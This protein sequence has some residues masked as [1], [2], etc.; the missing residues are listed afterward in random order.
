M[1][2]SHSMQPTELNYEIYDKELL[3]IFEAFQQWCN[4]LRGQ[5]TLYLMLSNHKNLEYYVTTM[6]LT[7]S[8]SP[9]VRIP[10]W[11]QLFDM[12]PCRKVGYQAIVLT[13]NEDVYPWGE[14]A[15][16]LANPPR[17]TQSNLPCSTGGPNWSQSFP[18]MPM[19]PPCHIPYSGSNPGWN[20]IPTASGTQAPSEVTWPSHDDHATTCHPGHLIGGPG[21]W[22]FQ[23]SFFPSISIL[24]HA[25]ASLIAPKLLYAYLLSFPTWRLIVC[26]P[27]SCLHPCLL[28]SPLQTVTIVTDTLWSLIQ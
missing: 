3:A 13:N 8:P 7:S 23:P 16:M 2:Y 22:R 4:Y 19:G 27:L 17:F 15:Y 9:L 10:F 25:N 11:I 5:H 6:Q 18:T 20:G 12:L 14:N 1:F 24:L 28:L 26:A 21:A